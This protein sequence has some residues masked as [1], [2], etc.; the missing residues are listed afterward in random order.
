MLWEYAAND[1]SDYASHVG[2]VL[3][4]LEP[5]RFILKY[6]IY[7]LHK[8]MFKHDVVCSALI[9]MACPLSSSQK[10][11]LPPKDENAHHIVT[12]E[13]CKGC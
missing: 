6:T 7:P 5:Q 13:L 10:A 12:F 4:L 3:I 8:K 11:Q 9:V 1:K 2:Y